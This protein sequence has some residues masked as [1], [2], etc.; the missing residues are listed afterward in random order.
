VSATI[1]LIQVSLLPSNMNSV[2]MID[3][4]CISVG[5]AVL[6]DLRGSFGEVLQY[7]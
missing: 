3:Y 2:V 1:I 4:F 6:Q 5:G 7:R